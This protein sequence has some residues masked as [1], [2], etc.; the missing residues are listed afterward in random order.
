MPVPSPDK[1]GGS[2][3]YQKLGFNKIAM[4][5]YCVAVMYFVKNAVQ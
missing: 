4:A 1:S 2:T 5:L 3:S